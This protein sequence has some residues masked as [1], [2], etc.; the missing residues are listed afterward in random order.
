MMTKLHNELERAW[1]EMEPGMWVPF[2]MSDDGGL[3]VRYEQNEARD[4]EDA[5]IFTFE[6]AV[7]KDV[8]TS[9]RI[10]RTFAEASIGMLKPGALYW[11]ETIANKYLPSETFTDV[12]ESH[13][14]LYERGLV[15]HLEEAMEK[16]VGPGHNVILLEADNI[17][18]SPFFETVSFKCDGAVWVWRGIDDSLEMIRT[19]EVEG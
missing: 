15:A 12:I 1:C 10:V 2:H 9:V 14:T 4:G 6:V 19:I 16:V 7:V 13:E 11:I 17:P 3:F 5:D 8:R 18:G